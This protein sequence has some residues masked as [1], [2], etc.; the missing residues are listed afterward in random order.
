MS[1][2]SSTRGARASRHCTSVANMNELRIHVFC[3][4]AAIGAAGCYL[5]HGR[6]DPEDAPDAATDAGVGPSC[7]T[8]CGVP[9]LVGTRRL[10]EVGVHETRAVLGIAVRSEAV[11][12]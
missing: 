11:A 6:C 2:R 5:A 1:S 8:R 10:Q 7:E 3:F 9:E 4:A 12:V